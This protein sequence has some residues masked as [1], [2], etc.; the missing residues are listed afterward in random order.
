[1]AKITSAYI[2]LKTSSNN[3]QKYLATKCLLNSLYCTPPQNLRDWTIFSSRHPLLNLSFSV[4][5]AICAKRIYQLRCWDGWEA[6][7]SRGRLNSH[8]NEGRGLV[9]PARGLLS[10]FAL[11]KSIFHKMTQNRHRPLWRWTPYVRP[12]RF[13]IGEIEKNRRKT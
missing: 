9:V 13:R 10:M 12:A 2:A 11:K 5:A 3:Y 4:D 1:L 8:G 6:H 7:V